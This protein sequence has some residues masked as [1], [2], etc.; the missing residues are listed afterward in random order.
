MAAGVA[1]ASALGAGGMAAAQQSAGTAAPY[2]LDTV[3]EKLPFGVPYGAPIGLQRAQSVIQA[4]M[5]EA[6]KRGWPLNIAVVDS[7]G[8]L[9]SMVRMDGAQ[10][11]SIGIAEH[12]ARTSA[13]FRRPT[14]AFEEAIQKSDYKYVTTIDDV[15]ASRGGIPLIEDGKLIGAVG[16]SGGAGSQDEIV[17]TA[18]AA[19]VNR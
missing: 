10:L 9:V 4:A 2:P 16:C 3:P 7:G 5:A 12:K 19:V 17:C 13:R 6:Q 15:I 11:A 18:G 14:R 8:N 1:L